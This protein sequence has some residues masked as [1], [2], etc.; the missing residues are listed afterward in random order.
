MKLLVAHPIESRRKMILDREELEIAK[1][2]FGKLPNVLI[3]LEDGVDYNKEDKMVRVHRHHWKKV[4]NQ[5]VGWPAFVVTAIILGVL[6][7][8][9]GYF[10]MMSGVR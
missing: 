4:K 2:I 8:V 6:I 10:I 5:N 7:A 1:V 9:V 3:L